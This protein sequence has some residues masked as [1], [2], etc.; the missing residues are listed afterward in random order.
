MTALIKKSTAYTRMFFMT[1]SSDHITGKTGLTVTV[2]L[3]KNGGAFAAAGGSITE[4]SS[5]WYKINLSTTDTNTVGDLAAHCTAPGADATDFVDQVFTR[6]LDDM[7]YPAT[8]GRSMVV[9][10]NGLVD[11]N[12]VKIGPTGSGTAQTA[13]DIGASVLLSSGTGTGQLDFTSGVVKGNVTQWLGTAV[14]TPT[15]A[16]VPNVNV[17]TWN[18]LATVALPLVPTTAGRTLDVSV[19]GEA[20]IDWANIGSPTTSNNLSGTN[21][22]TS[23]KVDVD[24]IKTN[25]VVNAGTVTFPTNSTLASTTNITAGTIATVTN[26][27]NAPTNGDLTATMK[28]SVTTA[29]TAATPTAAAVTGAV[30]SVTGNVG[31]NVNGNVVGSVASVV[32]AVGSVT[33]LT[34]SNLDVAVSTRLASADYTAPLSA[35][36]VRTAVGLASADLDTQLAALP[37]AAENSAAVWDETLSGHLV[38][39]STGAALNAA[40]SAGDPWATMLPGAYGAGTAGKIIG[41]TLDAAVSTRLADAD[42]TAPDNTAIGA[43]KTKTDSLNFGVTGQV[44]ANIKYVNDIEIFGSGTGGSPWGP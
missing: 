5:G 34:A 39:G 17:K 40:G 4:V 18:D 42:Y 27:T 2:T 26:L 15:V 23:Q 19:G 6:T 1:D 38:A 21:I 7:A 44:D 30:G 9:D 32:G 14:S 37:T 24:T 35:A 36:G 12:T 3:S 33:G 43:I 13:R 29:A 16:G 8:S 22:S 20:G 10:A 11:A 28:A 25:P 31:G 41:D